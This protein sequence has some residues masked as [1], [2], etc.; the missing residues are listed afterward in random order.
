MFDSVA[1]SVCTFK[2]LTETTE[3]NWRRMRY[4]MQHRKP[5][6]RLLNLILQLQGIC[7]PEMILKG[8]DDMKVGNNVYRKFSLC[9]RDYCKSESCIWPSQRHL[10]WQSQKS[11][12]VNDNARMQQAGDDRILYRGKCGRMS[13][14][15]IFLFEDWSKYKIPGKAWS[16]F[17]NLHPECW[18]AD[19]FLTRLGSK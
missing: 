18:G 3:Y 13:F 11:S 14:Q 9:G 1:N 12:G 4:K 7:F 15:T 8:K 19:K 10:Y 16:R 17:K 6:L 5:F 2:D